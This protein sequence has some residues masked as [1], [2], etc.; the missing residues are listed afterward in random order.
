[1]AVQWRKSVIWNQPVLIFHKM[2]IGFATNLSWADDGWMMSAKMV[3]PWM[4]TFE[5]WCTSG[6]GQLSPRPK[7][8]FDLCESFKKCAGW[9]L[10]IPYGLNLSINTSDNTAGTF[11]WGKNYIKQIKLTILALTL[12]GPPTHKRQNWKLLFGRTVATSQGQIVKLMMMITH[13][14]IIILTED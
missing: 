13:G 5:M 9:D 8:H 7:N 10:A 2:L 6:S 11:H 1:M 3:K 4:W 12:M 14:V